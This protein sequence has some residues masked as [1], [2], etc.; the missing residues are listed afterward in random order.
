MK[1]NVRIIMRHYSASLIAEISKLSKG[2][3]G[4]AVQ[5]APLSHGLGVSDISLSEPSNPIQLHISLVMS[6]KK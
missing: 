2:L 6:Q 4:P 5:S 1:R 3:I